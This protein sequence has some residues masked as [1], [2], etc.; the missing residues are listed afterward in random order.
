MGFNRVP[1]NAQD[2]SDFFDAESFSQ[3]GH[4]LYHSLTKPVIVLLVDTTKNTL[5]R[6]GLI[7]NVQ[8]LVGAV[9]MIGHADF[10]TASVG[11]LRTRN[12]TL[13]QGLSGLGR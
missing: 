13:L 4:D 5:D 9:A 1:V 11:L 2:E 12:T 6:S 8:T 3:E 10:G 7:V